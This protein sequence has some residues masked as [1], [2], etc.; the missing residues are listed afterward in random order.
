MANGAVAG[1]G[2]NPPAFI[3]TLRTCTKRSVLKTESLDDPTEAA[4]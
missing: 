4:P 2:V 3:G 1:F